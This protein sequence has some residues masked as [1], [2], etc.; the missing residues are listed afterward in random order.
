[1][2]RT[3][4]C[5][6]ACVL[7]FSAT[8]ALAG[9]LANDTTSI[10]G[11]HGSVGFSNIHGLAGVIDYA[12]WA[13]G[14]WATTGFSGF[15]ATDYVYTYQAY[16]TGPADLSQVSV[17]LTGPVDNNIGDFT[18]DNGFGPV[19]G[20]MSIAAY[21]DPFDS[22]NWLLDFIGTGASTD[23]L[24]FSSPNGPIWAQARVVDDG[25]VA[26]AIPVPSPNPDNVP[27]P[28]TLILASCGFA[29]LAVQWLRR[30][31]LMKA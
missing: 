7:A 31:K 12:V 4:N 1:M 26:F 6:L 15:T 14:T 10:A 2:S 23:G 3:K 24:A 17:T 27:E 20:D 9:P 21:I 8:H 30:G 11:F 25:T 19:V 13:P 28:G 18:G 22:A 5:L 16:V 29:V